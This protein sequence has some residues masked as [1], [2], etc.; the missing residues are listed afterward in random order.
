M[1]NSTVQSRNY[2]LITIFVFNLL[3]TG[4]ARA[5]ESPEPQKAV[6]SFLETLKS[7]RFPVQDEVAHAGLIAQARIF[8]D[9]EAIG[10]R[11]LDPHY[12]TASAEQQKSYLD[13]LN[14]LIEKVAY[15]RSNDSIGK[16][17][18]VYLETAASGA[19][20]EV[21]SVI[22]QEE[23]AL[24]TYVNY[25]LR[26][27]DG[28]WKIDDIVLDEVSLT[29]DL[30][31]QFDKIILQSGFEGLLNKMRERLDQAKTETAAAPN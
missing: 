26:Q 29:E 6:Q 13:L 5:A 24:D 20:Y 19:G 27:K 2:F 14:Q 4:A 18:V 12:E 17:E 11:S 25:H 10:K 31:Y 28:Q 22:K 1:T 16:F 9:L 8:L 21:Q 30:K 3:L 23:E 7:M 15:P